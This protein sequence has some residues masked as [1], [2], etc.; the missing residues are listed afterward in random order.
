MKR[1]SN[2]E[3]VGKIGILL[4]GPSS[5]REISIK[6]G[7]TVYDS[8]LSLG[9]DAV[10]IDVKDAGSFKEETLSAGIDIAFIA[11]H[12]KFGEDGRVQRALDDMNIPYIGSGPEASRLALDK[13]A[14]KEIFKEHSI[15]TPDYI[16][17]KR[18][19]RTLFSKGSNL[20]PFALPFVV[21]PAKEG[22]SIGMSIV[23]E[24]NMIIPALDEAFRYDD[25]VILEEYIKGDDITVGILN[26]KPLPVIKIK[27]KEKFYNFTA[28][29]TKGV[30][31]YI[32]PAPLQEKTTA[33]AQ[34]LGLLA[35]SVLGCYS[36]S[37][38]DMLISREDDSFTVLEV[39]TIPGL[40]SSSLLPKAA[41]AA[42]ID[43]GQMCVNMLEFTL[44]KDNNRTEALPL[45]R[46]FGPSWPEAGEYIRGPFKE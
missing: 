22:S 4:G 43:F 18:D 1:V 35:H 29:Y 33:L 15:P 39:N 9:Y 3:R 19:Q 21:K 11:L 6:S 5:E 2:I 46:S 38:V 31:E 7:N 45:P 24:R 17:L 13:T 42:G 37:R 12:G 23:Q 28:K 10:K 27:P 36:F 8:L 41:K 25:A 32:V 20:P 44:D 26:E 40:T 14:S 30:S 34:Q 16:L